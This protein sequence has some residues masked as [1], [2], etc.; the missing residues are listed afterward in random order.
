MIVRSPADSVAVRSAHR[1]ARR[2]FTLVEMV[3]TIGIIVVL[4]GLTVSATVA[5]VERSEIRQ[6]ENVLRLLDT[7]V[8]EWEAEADRKLTWGVWDPGSG[9]TYDMYDAVPH[10]YTVSE[11]LFRINKSESVRLI[12]GQIDPDLVFRYDT[13]QD[14]PPWIRS[15]DPDDPDLQSGEAMRW[16]GEPE[17]LNQRPITGMLAVLDAWGTPIRAVHPGRAWVAAADEIEVRDDDGTISVRLELDNDETTYGAEEFYGVVRA[18]RI[19]LVSAG[20]DGKFGNLEEAADSARHDEIHDN[21][22]SYT[23]TDEAHDEG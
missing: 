15:P 9:R 16:Y 11:A 19:L 17:G 4:A 18:Q 20:P 1:G 7:A 5:L 6:T 8:Q 3:V 23:V 2:S 22:Y 12:V 10:V 14:A 21:I 13:S